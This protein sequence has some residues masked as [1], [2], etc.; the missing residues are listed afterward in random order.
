MAQQ[1]VDE[2][3][4]LAADANKKLIENNY[5]IE[6]KLLPSAINIAMKAKETDEIAKDIKRSQP[7][8]CCCWPF[9]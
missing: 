5:E 8:C 4:V 7:C 1:K 2:N 6:E 9:W 3:I